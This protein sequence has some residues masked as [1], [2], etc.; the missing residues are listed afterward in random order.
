MLDKPRFHED[1]KSLQKFLV[2]T[3]S[4][5]IYVQRLLSLVDTNTYTY[6]H[7]FSTDARCSVRSDTAAASVRSCIEKLRRHSVSVLKR[8]VALPHEI[9]ASLVRNCRLFKFYWIYFLIPT[10]AAI[11][12]LRNVMDNFLGLSLIVL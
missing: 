3:I 1:R 6:P 7:N 2:G 12:I 8:V 11:F 4:M 5:L 9:H 10:L